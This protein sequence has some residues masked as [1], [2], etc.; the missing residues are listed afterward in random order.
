ML[1]QISIELDEE[2]AN[3]LRD[4]GVDIEIASTSTVDDCPGVGSTFGKVVDKAGQAVERLYRKAPLQSPPLVLSDFDAGVLGV[5][6]RNGA[7]FEVASVSTASDIPGPGRTLGKI[8]GG[9]GR[10][11]QQICSR[12]GDR[13]GLGPHAATKHIVQYLFR[14]HAEWEFDPWHPYMWCQTCGYCDIMRAKDMRP[15]QISSFLGN[16]VQLS[17]MATDLDDGQYKLEKIKGECKRLSKYIGCSS[18]Q[19]QAAAVFYVQVLRSLFPHLEPF[20]EEHGRG[21]EL[22][23]T[24]AQVTILQ[25]FARMQKPI[26]PDFRVPI[27]TATVDVLSCVRDYSSV[28]WRAAGSAIFASKSGARALSKGPPPAAMIL[29][30]AIIC[31]F[32]TGTLERHEAWLAQDMESH[33]SYFFNIFSKSRVRRWGLIYACDPDPLKRALAHRM[34]NALLKVLDGP[35]AGHPRVFETLSAILTSTR[36][37]RSINDGRAELTQEDIFSAQQWQLLPFSLSAESDHT[38]KAAITDLPKSIDIPLM[39]WI[40]WRILGRFMY[41]WGVTT[42]Q[43]HEEIYQER[44]PCA[45]SLTDLHSLCSHMAEVII[46]RCRDKRLEPMP[47]EFSLILKKDRDVFDILYKMLLSVAESGKRSKRLKAVLGTFATNEAFRVN[48]SLLLHGKVDLGAYYWKRKDL[49]P[50][51]QNATHLWRYFDESM[52]RHCFLSQIALFTFRHQEDTMDP[53]CFDPQTEGERLVGYHRGLRWVPAAELRCRSYRYR[54]IIATLNDSGNPAYFVCIR[55]PDFG[56]QGVYVMNRD[57]LYMDENVLCM[58]VLA[59]QVLADGETPQIYW[60]S[61]SWGTRLCCKMNCLCEFI[62]SSRRASFTLSM[63]YIPDAVHL[64]EALPDIHLVNAVTLEPVTIKGGDFKVVQCPT[65]FHGGPRLEW[66]G[67]RWYRP[68]QPEELCA[69]YVRKITRGF[70]RSLVNNDEWPRNALERDEEKLACVHHR[71][72]D[73]D[74]GLLVRGILARPMGASDPR[75]SSDDPNLF[76]ALAESSAAIDSLVTTP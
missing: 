48:V 75:S 35:I 27:D 61:P 32:L 57:K 44:F 25:S 9:L 68:L 10:V 7:E 67:E 42:N 20:F 24:L 15:S 71:E 5:I 60:A 13:M 69:Q 72:S 18:A 53:Q 40:P 49:R 59:A 4:N 16:M 8:V 66:T 58:Y 41:E 31:H 26:L 76:R 12:I 39:D 46:Q 70:L 14:P 54:A 55:T 65:W 28:E 74:A 33:A 45:V 51:P 52:Q 34:I 30:E 11:F 21:I 3:T 50:Y 37:Q 64:P 43:S 62:E 19:S 47:Y 22:Q 73:D 1:A 23:Q 29:M 6:S 63:A 17:M 2:V 38:L 56:L 36:F